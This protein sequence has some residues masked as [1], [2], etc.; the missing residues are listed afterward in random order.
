MKARYDRSMEYGKSLARALLMATILLGLA[1]FL[2]AVGNQILQLVLVL[3]SFASLGGMFY[4]LWRYCRCPYCGKR[5]IAGALVATSC[6]ACHRSF[7]TGKKLKK[8]YR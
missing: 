4:V 7:E 6:P 8:K 3:L 5:I 1:A 2:L